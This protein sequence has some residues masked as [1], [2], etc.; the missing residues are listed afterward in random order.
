[1][2]YFSTLFGKELHM[3]WTDLLSTIRSHNTVFIAIRICH[4]TYVAW[5]P[6][7]ITSMTSTY[8]CEYSIKTPDG[9]Q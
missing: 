4:T 5:P 1:M 3:F 8:C 2:H 9:G 7:H 6:E